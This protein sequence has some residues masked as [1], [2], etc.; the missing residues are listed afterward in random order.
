M[1]W[2]LDGKF[3]TSIQAQKYWKELTTFGF[4]SCWRKN[5]RKKTPATDSPTRKEKS[6][7]YY[8]PEDPYSD[9][10]SSDP[11][12]RNYDSSNNTNYKR[13]RSNK[14]KKDWKHKKWEPIKLCTKL[15]AKL[16]TPAYKSK[17]P[18]F[19]LDEDALQHRI[20]FFTFMEPQEM[21]FSK[22]K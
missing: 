1:F 9:L 13:R 3:Q 10:S 20:Y 12:L 8:V 7:K 14:N 15:T 17:V 6:W 16:L 18:V 22:Y 21:I 5:V 11:S 4:D 19:K 2:N